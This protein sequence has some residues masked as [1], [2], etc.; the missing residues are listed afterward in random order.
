VTVNGVKA[1]QRFY[2]KVAGAEADYLGTGRYDL[3]LSFGT[4]TPPLAQVRVSALTLSVNVQLS[5][6][7]NESRVNTT[8]E[9]GDPSGVALQEVAG[10]PAA[11]VSD[12]YEAAPNFQDVPAAATAQT[13][14]G[15]LARAPA[16]AQ[17]G[18]GT[19]PG[20]V[21]GGDVLAARVGQWF[22]VLVNGQA[23]APAWMP[24]GGPTRS[25]A[26]AAAEETEPLAGARPEPPRGGSEPPAAC[27]ACFGDPGWLAG[28]LPGPDGGEGPAREEVGAALALLSAPLA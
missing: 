11:R 15:G 26:P 20:A 3:A 16:P 13:P 7:G 27:D 14:D 5:L 2:V 25:A 4:A 1:G 10:D 9:V 22:S 6:V 23:A 18:A 24:V 17:G 19:T 28:L 8:T 12:A 21:A